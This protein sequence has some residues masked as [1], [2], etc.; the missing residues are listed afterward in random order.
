M[1]DFQSFTAR[2]AAAGHVEIVI[3]Q[4]HVWQTHVLPNQPD[5]DTGDIGGGRS[6]MTLPFHSVAFHCQGENC[7]STGNTLTGQ[8]SGHSCK[9]RTRSE[10]GSMTE[11]FSDNMDEVLPFHASD[12]QSVDGDVPTWS[13]SGSN[14][15][16]CCQQT[17]STFSPRV[18]AAGSIVSISM[19]ATGVPSH[20]P[21]AP[22][23][24]VEFDGPSWGALPS[25]CGC[26]SSAR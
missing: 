4:A 20:K 9:R 22:R 6:K 3:I 2:R 23:H 8:W 25:S 24:G 16:R 21:S 14:I 26:S 11:A 19:H 13:T 10:S 17:R 7:A 5:P 15:R 1:V 12:S 18:P